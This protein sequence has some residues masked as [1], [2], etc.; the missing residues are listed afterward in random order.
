MPKTFKAVS[1][2]LCFC[3][4][5]QQAGFAQVVG[6]LDISSH[7]AAL[8]NSLTPDKFR[9]LH[10]RFLSYS[11]I[12]N[13][14]QILLDKGTASLP[15]TKDAPAQSRE[16]TP[17]PPSAPG[18]EPNQPAHRLT[19]TPVNQLRDEAK[20]LLTYFLTGI[21]LPD[22]TF[23]VN[24]RPDS[25]DNIIDHLVEQTDIGKVFLE[26]D[27]QL[28]RDTAQFTS[29][30]SPEGRLY[31]DRLYKKAEELYGTTPASIP[32][33]TR[34]WIVPGEI[35]VRETQGVSEYQ[36]VK[37]SGETQGLPVNPE[38]PEQ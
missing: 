17:T 14:F 21:T 27:L 15:Q 38:F 26:A 31:W 10:L 37:A 28:K 19:G 16:L 33:I 30:Q 29:P 5:F 22:D 25:P 35:I 2:L 34:P 23:W 7:L 4:L 6:E 9:P 1:I 18:I 24:L 36:S 13:T 11:P 3:L 32:T 20:R 8:R 12:D